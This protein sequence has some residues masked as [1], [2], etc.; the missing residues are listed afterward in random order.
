MVWFIQRNNLKTSVVLCILSVIP[1][2][3]V[4]VMEAP[5]Y[6][7]G[8]S[9]GMLLIIIAVGVNLLIRTGMIKGSYDTLLQEGEFTKEQKQLKKKQIHFLAYTGV[10]LQQFILDGASRAESGILPGSYGQLLVFYLRHCLELWKWLLEKRNEMLW[11][12]LL[13]VNSFTGK[14]VHY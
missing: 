10:W 9:V 1:R 2:I 6:I 13:L 4:G 7:C 14:Q 8:I 11:N 3:I 12:V 5:D